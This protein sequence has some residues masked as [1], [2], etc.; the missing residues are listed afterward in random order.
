MPQIPDGQNEADKKIVQAKRQLEKLMLQFHQFLQDKILTENKSQGQQSVEAD[1]FMR[2][3]M[4]ANELDVIHPPEGTYGL[5]TLL[6]RQG[7][8]MRDNNNQ[9]EYKV[10]I[11]QQ[12]IDKLKNQ[13]TDLSRVR[14]RS[15]EE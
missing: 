8:V 7:F 11:L 14:Q 13:I 9:L 1:F 15:S 10:K 3:L 5:I 2:L 12:S 6:I 4:A